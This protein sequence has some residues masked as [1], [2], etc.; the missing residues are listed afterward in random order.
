M[1]LTPKIEKAIMQHEL[2]EIKLMGR[3]T[4]LVKRELSEEDIKKLTVGLISVEDFVEAL[5]QNI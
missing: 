4:F 2:V 5:E 3:P 1:I